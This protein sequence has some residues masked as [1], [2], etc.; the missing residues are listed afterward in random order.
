MITGADDVKEAARVLHEWGGA[1]TVV[2]TRGEKGVLIYDGSFREFQALPIEPEEIVDPT[3]GGGR[4]CRRFPRWLF[5]GSS[6][7]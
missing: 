4:L 3:G 1:K 2:I 5:E 6:P 7:P